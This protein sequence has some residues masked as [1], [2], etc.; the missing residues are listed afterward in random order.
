[1]KILHPDTPQGKSTSKIRITSPGRP[2]AYAFR[3][4]QLPGLDPD[5]WQAAFLLDLAERHPCDKQ[6]SKERC[7]SCEVFRLRMKFVEMEGGKP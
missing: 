7:H 6:C 3:F 2:K 5:L 1:M 4:S